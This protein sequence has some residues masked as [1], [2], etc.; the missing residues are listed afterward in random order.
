MFAMGHSG[1]AFFFIRWKPG[2]DTE[3]CAKI[4]ASPGGV[5]K[6]LAR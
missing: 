6:G 3:G 4:P 2:L 5:T 1:S